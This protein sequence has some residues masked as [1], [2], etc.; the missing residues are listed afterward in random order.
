MFVVAGQQERTN[1][2]R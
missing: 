2:L 1:I